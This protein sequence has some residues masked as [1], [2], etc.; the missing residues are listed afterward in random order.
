MGTKVV[1]WGASGHALVVADILR[2]CGQHEIIGLLDDVNPGRRGQRAGGLPVLG[3][4]E[5]IDELK[6]QGLTHVIFGFG[7]CG[8]R[9]RL[10]ETVPAMGL[11]F[12]TAIHPRAIVAADATIGAGTVIAAGAVV[13]PGAVVGCH[14]II[15]TCASVDHDCVIGN[16]VHLSPGV[17]LGGL[18]TVG[19][20]AWICIGATV[21][22]RLKIGTRSIIGA[23][24][25]ITKDVSEG[26]VVYGVPGKVIRSVATRRNEGGIDS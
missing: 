26:V 25:V 11:E 4:L 22:D 16:A 10:A 3:D 1:I 5:Q 18:V 21:C 19:D 9:L 15:N 7:D 12:A 23:G 2:L 14:C 20:A 24:S 8:A 13:N 17:H 6:R